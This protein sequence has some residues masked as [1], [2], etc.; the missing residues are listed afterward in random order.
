[1]KRKEI[2]LLMGMF[3][4]MFLTN[5]GI[6]IL[7]LQ[8]SDKVV[9]SVDGEVYGTYPQYIDQ[10][11][12]INET[13]VLLIKDGKVDM[14]EANC[15]D[16]ICVDHVEIFN[17]GETIVCLPNKVVVEI[18]EADNAETDNAETDNAEV[19]AVTN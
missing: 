4:V 6:Q 18:Q 11:I 3:V 15:P 13:N 1:M 12:K 2:L 9:V 5:T 10:E 19:D 16:K 8:E 7:K 14:I 17:T